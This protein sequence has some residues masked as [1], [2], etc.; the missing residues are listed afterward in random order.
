MTEAGSSKIC[1]LS[2]CQLVCPSNLTDFEAT[3][4]CDETASNG[5]VYLKFMT[6][7]Y[8]KF[9]EDIAEDFNAVNSRVKVEIV[10][11]NMTEMAPNIVNEAESKTGIFDGLI[12]PPGVMGSV[13]DQEGWADLTSYIEE[14][15]ERSKDW[16]DILVAY[17]KS[18]AQYQNRIL[19]YPMDGDV[20]HLFY[21]KD[22][23]DHF[24][25]GVPRTWD[26]YNAVAKT[27]HR[28]SFKNETLT[29]SCVGQV[30]G[31]AGSYWANLVLSSMTQTSG[32]GFGH[33]F[34]TRNMR[35]LLGEALIQALAW[36]EEQV[37][38]GAPDEFDGC[39]DDINDQINQGT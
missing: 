8:G 38:Y 29:G 10:V 2:T 21:R 31:C 22:V 14:S 37:Q 18:I 5:V 39:I 12:S 34:D 30:F 35:P 26:E 25:L 3:F 6:G 17:R 1:G 20:L 13:V 16:S 15:A 4:P 19:M 7:E 32:N 23:L 27:V 36:M 28:R 9:I 11:V 33:L 24:G